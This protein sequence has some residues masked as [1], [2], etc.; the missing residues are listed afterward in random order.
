VSPDERSR[1]APCA[2]TT[3]GAEV[4]ARRRV[5]AFAWGLP[6]LPA[7]Y[8][9][10]ALWPKRR[11]LLPNPST[12]HD[13]R[14]GGSEAR[15]ETCAPA[16]RRHNCG[17][18]GG[19]RARLRQQQLHRRATTL[20]RPCFLGGLLVGAV[21]GLQVPLGR[22]G[23]RTHGPASR[24][25]VANSNN[26]LGHVCDDAFGSSMAVVACRSHRI[27]HRSNGLLLRARKR[28]P[29]G[30]SKDTAHEADCVHRGALPSG[31]RSPPR[32]PAVPRDCRARGAPTRR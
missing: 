9:A 17:A 12:W 13:L 23:P 28:G 31:S 22:A 25:R 30:G 5:P 3:F 8:R 2:A 11:Q 15:L 26:A 1:G 4:N 18:L 24:W 6:P 14:C 27:H 7:S 16:R 21:V 29:F 32:M 10:A 19:H 20:L